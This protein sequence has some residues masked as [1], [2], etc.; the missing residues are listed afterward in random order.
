MPDLTSRQSS[1]WSDDCLE[2]DTMHGRIYTQR[3][4]A[5]LHFGEELL[6]DGSESSLTEKTHRHGR[7][8][9]QVAKMLLLVTSHRL[10][11]SSVFMVYI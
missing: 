2:I 4:R 1:Q 5:N 11:T 6:S 10:H 7:P 9:P 3:H 8:P